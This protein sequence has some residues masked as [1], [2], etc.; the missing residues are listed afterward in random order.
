[1]FFRLIMM[2]AARHAGER[3]INFMI[4]GVPVEREHGT[5]VAHGTGCAGTR[6]EKTGYLSG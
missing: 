6:P 4:S 5:H 3:A 2:R 1:V